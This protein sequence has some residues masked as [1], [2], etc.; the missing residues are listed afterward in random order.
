MKGFGSENGKSAS[1]NVS[2]SKNEELEEVNG[3]LNAQIS[4]YNKLI[5]RLYD[6]PAKVKFLKREVDVNYDK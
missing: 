4:E 1:S 6:D 3:N 2:Q 5:K